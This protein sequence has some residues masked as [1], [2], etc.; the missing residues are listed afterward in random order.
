M[1]L[2]KFIWLF[3][4]LVITFG[5]W[6]PI[7]LLFI[8]SFKKYTGKYYVNS[9]QNYDYAIIVTAY[10]QTDLIP[11]VVKSILAMN[12]QNYLVY[13][14]ADNCDISGLKFNDD[15]IH[16]LRPEAILSSNVKSHIYAIDHFKRHHDIITIIDSDNLIHPE[17]INEMNVFF[18]NGFKAVQGVRAA[19]NLNTNY[20][21]LDEAS[22][23]YYRYVD[24]KLLY[25][26]GSSATLAG[27]GMAF[28]AELYEE[29]LKKI[30]ISG[31]GFD[32]LLQYELVKNDIRIAFAE[33]AIVYDGKTAKTD[34]LV[35][36]RARWIS[37]W[38]KS[39][40]LG[41]ELLFT[42]VKK[43]S[44]NLIA[45]SNVHLR[46][47][48]FILFFIYI[49]FIIIDVFFIQR[50]TIYFLM[51]FILFLI[52]FIT[53]LLYFKAKKEIYY[54]LL[55]IPKFI[56]FQVIALFYSKNANK[57]SVATKHEINNA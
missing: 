41:W 51:I 38:A 22:D 33:N 21:C 57:I 42:G 4:Q 46:P 50:I 54:A 13:I 7:V 48:L 17:Y 32:K 6:F 16:I 12:Y 2:I 43:M 20:A 15:R 5:L 1:T 10:L 31:A 18:D 29:A 47:P 49:V 45:F 19:R 28:T 25:E 35:K 53:S 36:Q 14:V 39:W 56:F 11:D 37:A 40:K 24:R 44:W 52:S 26:S 3:I 55:L 23:M 34:Q 27:S 9:S 8:S 30:T